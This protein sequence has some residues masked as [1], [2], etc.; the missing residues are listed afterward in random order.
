MTLP[1]FHDRGTDG[2]RRFRSRIFGRTARIAAASSI[3]LTLGVPVLANAATA[4]GSPYVE[5]KADFIYNFLFVL[6]ARPNPAQH[7]PFT[8]V[9]TK[10]WAWGWV[11]QAL[12]LG[13]VAPVSNS[14]FGANAPVSEAE[15]AAMAVQYFH[16]PLKSQET[17][18]AWANSLGLFAGV[19]NANALTL[20]NELGF[21]QRLKGYHVGIQPTPAGWKVS[22][23]DANSLIGAMVRSNQSVFTQEHVQMNVSR[24]LILTPSGKKDF[25]AQAIARQLQLASKMLFVVQRGR[26]DGLS[27]V[28]EQIGGTV[29]QAGQS[30]NVKMQE[31]ING[32][33]VYINQGTGWQ[34]FPGGQGILS[35]IQQDLQAGNYLSTDGLTG[36]SVAQTGSGSVYRGALSTTGL[37]V[38]ASQ[39]STAMQIPTSAMATVN[40]AI[41]KT[42]KSS[43]A[44]NTASVQG[45]DVVTGDTI[46]VRFVLPSKLLAGQGAPQSPTVQRVMKEIQGI[47]I[48]ETVATT[49]TYSNTPV[50][51]PAS[52]LSSLAKKA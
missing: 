31:Y 39:V 23:Q 28:M 20:G 13:I 49:Y 30:S 15:A 45:Q 10:S 22:N 11:H 51:P 48:Q 1:S 47:V 35:L 21:L 36:V 7:S 8:D 34:A 50:L 2:R 26:W 6:G 4:S 25:Q 44:I 52:L 41:M 3:L 24:A 9:P 38:F 12:D 40:Q 27:S 16:V 19:Q 37:T 46:N 18:T 42:A 33:A 32:D 5:P 17:P 43:I 14:T 29:S